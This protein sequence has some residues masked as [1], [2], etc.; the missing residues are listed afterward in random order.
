[1]SSL[2]IQKL[3]PIEHIL[4][5]PDMYVGST[6]LKEAE[7][8]IAKEVGGR[9]KI[10]KQTIVFPPA[11]LRI[12]VEALSNAIDNAQRSKE[13]KVT[14]SKIKVTIN[15]ETG[16]TTVWN[17]GL[18]IPVT[19]DESDN[20]TY[21]H[22]LI[23]GELRTSTNFN[24]EE[25]RTVS[26]RNG[27]GIKLTNVFSSKFTVK[28][29]DPVQ[30]KTFR[31]QWK[32]NMRDKSDVS[33]SSSSAKTGFTEVSWI[34][35]FEQFGVTGYT[36]EIIQLYTRYVCD[37]AMLSKLNVY[38]N[39][40]KL[41]V[42]SLQDYAKLYVDFDPAS[43]EKEKDE[44]EVEDEDK[45]QVEEEEKTSPSK[46]PSKSPS[47]KESVYIKGKDS[48]VFL[49]PSS[50]T[51]P[52]FEAVSFVN[53][54]FTIN[55]GKHVDGWSEALF[56]PIVDHF[57]SPKKPQVNIK[58]VKQFYRL[59]VV[60]TLVN[61]EF[62]SQS[63]TELTSPD[64]QAKVEKKIISSILKW[65]CTSRID[66]IIHSKEIMVMKKSESKKKGYKAIEGYDAA[67]EAGGKK[68]SEC[69]LALCEG[70]S[71]KT[72]AVKGMDATLFGK[73]GRD[74]LGV[75]PLRG[76][77]LNVRK[78]TPKKIAENRV[79]TDLIQIFN[80]KYDLDY[81]V[82]ENF[83]N[84]SYGRMLILTDADPDGKHIGALLI[85]FVHY[86]F[87]TLL[88]RAEPFVVHM[89]T[90]IAKFSFGKQK[91]IFYDLYSADEF[92]KAHE[93]DFNIK[94]DYYKGLGT[95]EDKEILEVFGK[96]V[97]SYLKDDECDKSMV[98]AFG[99]DTDDRKRWISSYDPTKRTPIQGDGEEV[100][101]EGEG[102]GEEGDGKSKSKS[103][104][105]TV[106]EAKLYRD[107]TVF[108]D[109][110]FI[111]F[112][113]DDCKRS[114]PNIIDGH[115]Q[116][117]RKIL[118][119][120]F[121]R[122]LTKDIKV[123]QLSGFVAEK[124]NYH[125]GE[126]ILS[127]TIIKMASNFVG[128]NNLPPLYGRG[129]FGSRL[130]NGQDAASPRYIFTRLDAITRLL[131]RK[132]DDDLLER[133][134][135]DGD[136][137]EPKYFVPI[138]PMVLINGAEG[139]G[140]GWSCDVPSFNPL[141]VVQQV[142]NWIENGDESVQNLTP[143]SRGFTGEIKEVSKGKFV[144]SGVIQRIEAKK[145]QAIITEIPIGMS[146]QTITDKVAELKE[147]KRIKDFRNYSTANTAYFVLD[148]TQDTMR[149]NVENLKLTS[150]INTTNMV[151]FDEN[152]QIRKYSSVKDIIVSFCKV[153][154]E[155]YVA[156]KEKMIKNLNL[157]LRTLK[158][159]RR[160]VEEVMTGVLVLNR[161]K[162]ETIE[163]E[164][165][166][167]DY[168]TDQSLKVE[169]EVQVDAMETSDKDGFNYLLKMQV[170]S[171]TEEKIFELDD[172][173]SKRQDQLSALES[174]TEKKMWV[175]DLEEFASEY[176]KWLKTANE[177]EKQ[178][179]KKR[180]G[181]EGSKKKDAKIKRV[182]KE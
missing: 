166:E 11:L 23:F 26:G 176:E 1:M 152:F 51:E 168:D 120:C 165:L 39:D 116:G 52:M 31:Q 146:I 88:Q 41:P 21:K 111:T 32:N 66:D 119:A 100:D 69:T 169:V 43:E 72:F 65:E 155:Y 56:R 61:P 149:C 24:D 47:L 173:I 158:N 55:G 101:V 170:S 159:R 113:I 107:I 172:L 10:Q 13:A 106:E 83:R 90:P 67:N 162:Q 109:E 156:R 151:M 175:L 86:L 14:A 75:Y 99:D 7:E 40:S 137:V 96:R 91:K 167:R 27:L 77:I 134:V 68:S 131:Y 117:Q 153:R 29:F 128:S 60:S 154:M 179:V 108:I 114:I 85:N 102:E 98:R 48:E 80:L 97:I 150:T 9:Y 177:L 141:D 144:T 118:Y 84:L 53:G 133:V 112:S 139:I 76:K 171:F 36:D 2:K 142:K 50:S 124:T 127:K 5:R 79:I 121:L 54:V 71:A 73:S 20:E 30:G 126:E 181:E 148:E 95:H 34:P 58:D 138:I 103:T 115:K 92:Y 94:V 35:D 15:K 25:E 16:E 129:Q 3:D 70:L 147:T 8:Y 93:K 19:V 44:V 135:D 45:G 42:K 33:I 4:K 174:T 37:A 110:E 22:S 17:D 6:R 161:K 89:L 145:N 57:N 49:M 59:F 62:S 163:F 164:L 87:P 18:V 122:N 140:T 104:E 64:V 63:K 78:A 143:W 136:I 74:W 105:R 130:Q 157:V 81:R 180:T 125:H 182:K 28:G 38:L 132:E 82:D 178:I 12:F 46:S 160:F 123:A